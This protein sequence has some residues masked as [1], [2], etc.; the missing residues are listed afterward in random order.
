MLTTQEHLQLL[1]VELSLAVGHQGT[2]GTL[3]HRVHEAHAPKWHLLAA[4]P[5]AEAFPTAA[6]VMLMRRK[7]GQ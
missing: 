7:V 6:A 3:A 2:V 5:V 4:T 1:V